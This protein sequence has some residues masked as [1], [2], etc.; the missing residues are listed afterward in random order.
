MIAVQSMPNADYCLLYRN[1]GSRRK[2]FNDQERETEPKKKDA[3]DPA[4]FQKVQQPLKTGKYDGI[5]LIKDGA[6]IEHLPGGKPAAP[7]APPETLARAHPAPPAPVEP[8]SAVQTDVSAP[9][10]ESVFAQFAWKFIERGISVVP[11]APGTKKPGQWSEEHGW[12]GMGDWTRFAKRLPTDIELEHWYTW[13]DAGIGVVLGPVS[14]LTCLD[15]DYDIPNGGNDALQAIIPYSPISKKGEKGWTRFYQFNGERSCSF[16]VGGARVLDVLADGRQTVVPPT[17]HPSGCSYVWITEEGLDTILSTNE[18]PKLPDNFLEQ[19][20]SVLAPYQN[21]QDI[22]HQ[23]KTHTAKDDDR[24]L[25][26]DLTFS[27]QYFRDLNQRALSCLDDWVPKIVPLAKHER[28]GYRTVATWRGAK[29]PNVGITSQGIRDWGGNYGL[30]AT[31]LVMWA[32]GLT[33]AQAAEVLRQHVQLAEPEPI[34]LTVRGVEEERPVVAPQAQASDPQP[35]EA[36]HDDNEETLAP[37][38]PGHLLNPPGILREFM[39]WILGCAQ[40]PQPVLALATSLSIV[41]T[42]LARKVESQTSLRTNLYLVGVAGTG[43][44]KDHGRKCLK[45][46]FHYAGLGEMVGGEE[47]ASGKGLLSAAARQPASVFQIDEFGL[48]LKSVRSKG[49]GTH[50]QEIVTNLMKLKSSAGSVYKGT[51]YA[52]QK[53]RPKEDIQYPCINLHAVTTPEPLFDSLSSADVASGYLNRLLILF[54]PNHRQP[55]RFTN[56]GSPPPNL[57]EWMKAARGLSQ[58]QLA[59]LDPSNPIRILMNSDAERLFR[60]FSYFQE[61]QIEKKALAGLFDLTH[62]KGTKKC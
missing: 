6:V 1:E 36:P 24:K 8:A 19:V 21:D 26:S 57:L 4:S 51:E 33:F 20:A 30:T 53:A 37:E 46:A 58:G 13:P 11:I 38:F 9:I 59:G 54:A 55:M 22:K 23:K 41:A 14:N 32:N 48:M 42:V 16:D 40:K 62:L 7:V 34:V 45:L 5:A 10:T 35:D 15:K 39:D 52:D 44:G 49:A 31:D 50:M 43:A 60:E 2:Y 3:A 29:N 47:F 18:L 12:R 28:D 56:I 17:M 25:D 27:A 61:E